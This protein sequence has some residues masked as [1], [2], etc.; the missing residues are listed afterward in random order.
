[1]GIETH[2]FYKYRLELKEKM[3]NFLIP[4]NFPDMFHDII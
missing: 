4:I 2:Q 1:M 3:K